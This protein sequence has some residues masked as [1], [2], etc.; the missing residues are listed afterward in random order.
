MFPSLT[1]LK[2]EPKI[3]P[4]VERNYVRHKRASDSFQIVRF[5]SA[6]SLQNFGQNELSLRHRL[7]DVTDL[8]LFVSSVDG[9]GD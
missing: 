1:R 3:C 6:S 7:T 8:V 2:I 5:K 9:L 4:N